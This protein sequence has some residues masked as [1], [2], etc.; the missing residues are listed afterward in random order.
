MNNLKRIVGFNFEN[1]ENRALRGKSIFYLK[2]KREGLV[3]Y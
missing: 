2:I 3:A 1:T